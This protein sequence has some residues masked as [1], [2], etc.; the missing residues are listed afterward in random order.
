MEHAPPGRDLLPLRAVSN[1]VIPA[2]AAKVRGLRFG[3]QSRGL[4]CYAP[5]APD[6]ETVRH[7][8]QGLRAE[9]SRC[10]ALLASLQTEGLSA[11]AR[12]MTDRLTLT[13]AFEVWPIIVAEFDTS[14]SGTGAAHV[15]R[16]PFRGHSARRPGRH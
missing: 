13:R 2:Q 4:Q 16:V 1:P 9:A 15:P 12:R 6:A 5:P 14:N 10:C 7:L 3:V 8:W 11:A